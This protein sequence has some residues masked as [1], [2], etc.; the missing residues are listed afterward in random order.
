MPVRV[1]NGLLD[2]GFTPDNKLGDIVN[3]PYEQ[4]KTPNFGRKSYVWLKEF[5]TGEEYESE[6][7]RKQREQKL[8]RNKYVYEQRKAGRT[9]KDIAEELGVSK[10]RVRQREG[11][12]M[13]YLSRG[14]EE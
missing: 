2:R 1:W 5:T 4:L 3:I 7:Y 13:R 6:A 14:G 8:A 11:Q 12:Y 9:L 10:E